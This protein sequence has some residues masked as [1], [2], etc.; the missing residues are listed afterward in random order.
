MN[1]LLSSLLCII[2][3]TSARADVAAIEN[4]FRAAYALH[5]GTTYVADLAAL[6]TKY[7]G[8]LERSIQSATQA[9]KLEEALGF[10]DEIQRINDKA[11][12]P[13]KDDGVAPALAKLRATYREQFAKLLATRNAAVA[14]IVEKFAAALAA[15]QEELTKA[16]NL[17]EAVAVKTYR[18]GD[19]TQRLTGQALAVSL[20]AATAVPEKPSENSLGMRFVPVPIIGGPSEGKTIR[21]SVWETR[22]KD[23]AAFVK[24]ENRKWPKPDFAQTDDHPAVNVSWEDATAFCEWLTKE[25]RR[26]QKIGPNDVYRM[27][28]DHEWSCAIGI[29]KEEDA[30]TAPAAKSMKITAYPW[31]P[32]F[33]PPKGAGNYNGEETRKDPI[34][35][36]VPVPGYDDGFARTAPVG[37]FAANAF[38]LHDLGGNVWEWSQDW[39]DPGNRAERVLRGSSWYYSSPMYLRA[40]NRGRGV[41]TIHRDTYG[42]RVVLEVGSAS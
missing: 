24:D 25:E 37:R 16:G 36:Q 20:T 30:S 18:E 3:A 13:D 21:F 40:S 5:V 26:K 11:P 1:P 9:G 15:H 17:Q 38:G 14:P 7:L 22:V 27:P 19:L 12:L 34:S 29:G 39:F 2:V 4:Q 42:F 41:P 28:T 10:Q 6:D 23:Y 32:G 35:G 33:P 8:A 31:G